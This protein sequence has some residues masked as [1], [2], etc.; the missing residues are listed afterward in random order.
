MRKLAAVSALCISCMQLAHVAPQPRSSNQAHRATVRVEVEC[1]E[2][3]GI[4]R[5]ARVDWTPDKLGTGV[6]ISERHVLTAAHVVACPTIPSV[7][8]VTADGRRFMARVERDAA[9]FEDGRDL[10][11]IYT[12]ENM[13][14]GIAPPAINPYFGNGASTVAVYGRESPTGWWSGANEVP[15]QTQRGDSGAGIY[16]H[17]KLIGIVTRSGEGFSKFEPVDASWMEGT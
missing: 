12:I 2:S 5:V 1:G 10:A 3:W 11:R 9:T 6:A 17:G 13:G 15:A 16:V 7:H 14:L 8:V 4:D